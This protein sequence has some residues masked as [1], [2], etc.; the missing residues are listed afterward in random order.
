[1]LFSIKKLRNTWR[2]I[3][4]CATADFDKM[5]EL[6][7]RPYWRS[8]HAFAHS[9]IR[10][11]RPFWTT[12]SKKEHLRNL[13]PSTWKLFK[14]QRRIEAG[15]IIHFPVPC[16]PIRAISS[17]QARVLEDFLGGYINLRAKDDN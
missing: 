1:M 11:A 7:N 9:W 12:W 2:E 16:S 3:G 15:F 13:V 4:D 10:H 14:A 6:V 5:L 17:S 8:T